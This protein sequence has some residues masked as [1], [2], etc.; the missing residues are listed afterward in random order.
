MKYALENII[1]EANGK[2]L[3]ILTIPL[4]PDFQRYAPLKAEPP[5][6]KKLNEFAKNNAV[7][8]VDLLAYMANFSEN[9]AEY[10]LP[11]DGHWNEYGHFV[12]SRYLADSLPMYKKLVP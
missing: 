7:T 2:E 4:L 5:L 1:Q 12:A 9:G 10:Y 8:Y 11:C 6:S 3:A